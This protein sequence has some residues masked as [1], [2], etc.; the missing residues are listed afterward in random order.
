MYCGRQLVPFICS[1]FFFQLLSV[2]ATCTSWLTNLFQEDLQ[3]Q[4]AEQEKQKEKLLPTKLEEWAGKRSKML[5]ERARSWAEALAA[6]AISGLILLVST[7]CRTP[8]ITL[9]LMLLILL[10]N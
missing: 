10:L 1:H 4:Q 8:C 2:V 9:G 3:Q 5:R 6:D 7:F